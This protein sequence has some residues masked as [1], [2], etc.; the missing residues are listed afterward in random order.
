MR[1]CMCVCNLFFL[2]QY[3]LPDLGGHQHTYCTWFWGALAAVILGSISARDKPATVP[4]RHPTQRAN[5]P[6]CAGW[7][8]WVKT[9]TKKKSR[10]LFRCKAFGVLFPFIS[11]MFFFFSWMAA[12]R[13]HNHTEKQRANGWLERVEFVV[14]FDVVK[15]AIY[16]LRF[17]LIKTTEGRD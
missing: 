6:T 3:P 16:I 8:H 17:T 1:Q 2:W 7:M 9:D 12:G 10:Q 14:L 5:L 4:V 15:Q 13:G 11:R